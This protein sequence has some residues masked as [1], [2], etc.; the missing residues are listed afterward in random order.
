LRWASRLDAKREPR[1][2]VGDS[3][4]VRVRDEGVSIAH[5]GRDALDRLGADLLAAAMSVGPAS[6]RIGSLAID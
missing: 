2:L 4:K 3:A 1:A 5:T 6:Q